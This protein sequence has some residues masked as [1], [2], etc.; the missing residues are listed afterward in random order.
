MPPRQGPSPSLTALTLGDLRPSMPHRLIKPG[1]ADICLLL[2]T[3]PGW[4]EG[5]GIG[6]DQAGEMS[7]RT[8]PLGP[9]VQAV[10]SDLHLPAPHSY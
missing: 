5:C 6:H 3:G 4:L 7:S 2:D 10:S 9:S 8:S 1:T